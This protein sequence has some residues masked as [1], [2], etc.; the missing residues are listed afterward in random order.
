M[1][2]IVRSVAQVMVHQLRLINLHVLL[3]TKRADVQTAIIFHSAQSAFRR[4]RCPRTMVQEDA[5]RAH[6]IVDLV[7]P[8]EMVNVIIVLVDII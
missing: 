3:V 8:T 7:L 5:Q 6:Q 4:L 1:L 2:A